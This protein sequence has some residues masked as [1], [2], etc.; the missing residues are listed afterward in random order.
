MELLVVTLAKTA[1]RRDAEVFARIRSIG[2]TLRSASGLVSF[3]Y[4]RSRGSEAYYFILTTWQDEESWQQAQERHNPKQLLLSSAD[5]LQAQPEQW[6]MYY[7]WG[8]SR[9]TVPPTLA[10]AHL[11]TVRSQH[12]ELVQ[13]GW[14]Q[15]LHQQSLQSLLTFAFLA[16]SQ[17]LVVPS[18]ST[19]DIAAGREQGYPQGP[20]LLCFFSWSS[21]VER[22]EFYRDTNYQAMS[23]FL[24]GIGTVHMLPLEPI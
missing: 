21:E 17:P 13:K 12:I 10:S 3:R 23:K 16:R 4:Y 8:Y 1:A 5:L 20:M 24:E 18:S 15:G 7:I 19:P 22:S 14:Q 9:P 2:D 6:L 11:I